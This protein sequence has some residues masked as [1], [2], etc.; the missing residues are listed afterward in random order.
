MPHGSSFA[1]NLP[2]IG[3]TK[4]LKKKNAALRSLHR[5]LVTSFKRE[6][7][8]KKASEMQARSST[9]KVAEVELA[10]YQEKWRK[11]L[12]RLQKQ[13]QRKARKET[14]RVNADFI[15]HI[16]P[17]YCKYDSDEEEKEKRHIAEIDAADQK[18]DK[19]RK[20]A[21]VRIQSVSR[22]RKLRIQQ[23]QLK[24][25]ASSATRI[26]AR[27]RGKMARLKQKMQAKLERRCHLEVLH[28]V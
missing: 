2:I 10:S 23:R 12:A 3:K 24:A 6:R 4:L 16:E 15:G 13:G 11:R 17:I 9:R 8:Q 26:Q 22:G 21:A 27:A 14:R 25:E 28:G 19:E 5:E 18:E 1:A 7:K 20:M